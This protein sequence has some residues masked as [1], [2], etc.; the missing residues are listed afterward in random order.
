[1]STAPW[2]VDA[3]RCSR[4]TRAA[5]STTPTP[6]RSRRTSSAAAAARPAIAR[7]VDPARLDANWLEIV[8]VLD[9]P[10]PRF[11]ERLLTRLGVR[12]A[13]RAAAR[14]HARR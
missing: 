1:M 2:H 13:R 9:A 12:A 11:V 5:T 6:T 7:L 14:R 4:R 10:R 8:D 3:E